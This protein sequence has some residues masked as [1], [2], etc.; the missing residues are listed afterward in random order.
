MPVAALRVG[1]IEKIERWMD[2][3]KN[4]NGCRPDVVGRIRRLFNWSAQQGYI[5]S[6][7]IAGLKKPRYNVRVSTFTP[8]Q[9]ES[10]LAEANDFFA[11]GFR[12]LLLTGCRPDE[13]C[14]LRDTDV[15][16]DS[17]GLYLLVNHKNQ[18]H[19]GKPRRV[20]LV[21]EAAQIIREQQA[22]YKGR[23]FRSG[24]KT[25]NGVRPPVSPEYFGHALRMICKK[26]RCKKLGLDE[27]E[28]IGGK[29]QYRYVPYTTRHTFAVRYLTGFYKDAK[30]RQIILNYGEVA[31]LL[32]NTAKNGR[33][34]LRPF[35]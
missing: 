8:E 3:H 24:N 13:I 31:A 14:R 18:R 23:L 25:S 9:V 32:G 16:E 30:G 35:G 22:K 12:M 17:S 2:A 5:P 27:H 34:N 4:W 15:Y 20:F 26:P 19:T 1:G 6:S 10:I 11:R 21:P 7:P 29:R 33:S 28:V